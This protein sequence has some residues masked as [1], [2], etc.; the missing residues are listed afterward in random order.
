MVALC[1]SRS[2]A[3]A[4]FALAAFVLAAA[5]VLRGDAFAE[6]SPAPAATAPAPEVLRLADLPATPPLELRGTTHHVQGIELDDERLWVTSVDRAAAKGFLHLFRLPSGEHERTVEVQ[7]GDRIHP[8][9]LCADPD[10][11]TLWTPVAAYTRTGHTWV[12]RRRKDDLSLVSRFEVEDHIGCVA[13]DAER[14]VGGNWDSI[15]L[16]VW[17]RQGNPIE[18][19]EN[20]T[21]IAYQDLKFDGPALVGSGNAKGPRGVA[22][23]VVEWLDLAT[24]EPTRRILAGETDRG[25]RFTNEGMAL[26]AGGLFLLPEDGPSRLFRFELP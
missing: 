16:Y 17:D 13:V 19:R 23:G 11:E 18:K 14:V 10:G 8:G 1:R 24:G 4:A 22:S 15:V 6:E 12:E 9:G 20:R 21:R 3:L 2:P 5:V 25:V 7:S 26:R